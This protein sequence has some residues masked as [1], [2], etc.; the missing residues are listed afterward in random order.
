MQYNFILSQH[1]IFTCRGQTTALPCGSPDDFSTKPTR[2]WDSSSLVVAIHQSGNL[3]LTAHNNGSIA[4][5]NVS[6][7]EQLCVVVKAHG[8]ERID[9]VCLGF[10]GK[11]AFSTADG[12]KFV[13]VWNVVHKDLDRSEGKYCDIEAMFCLVSSYDCFQFLKVTTIDS[14]YL[15]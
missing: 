3:I 15:C 8:D 11:L 6:K 13:R 4:L 10:D 7:L 2:S 12:D 9:D 5:H 1:I 14:L